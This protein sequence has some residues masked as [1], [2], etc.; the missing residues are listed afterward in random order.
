MDGPIQR[1][2]CLRIQASTVVGP[3]CAWGMAL[4]TPRQG[5]GLAYKPTQFVTNSIENA[6]ILD[7]DC[8]NRRGGPVRHISLFG[9]LAHLRAEITRSWSMQCCSASR[10]R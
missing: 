6:K 3:M 4:S 9:G 2:D 7:K 8:L 5:Q 1:W 10:D